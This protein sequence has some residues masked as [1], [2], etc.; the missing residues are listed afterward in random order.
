MPQSRDLLPV[1]L[2]DEFE[3]WLHDKGYETR[4]TKASYGEFEVRVDGKGYVIYRRQTTHAG[5]KTVHCSIH[6]PVVRLARKFLKERK[7]HE[8]DQG[9]GRQG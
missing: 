2:L 7:D 8:Q 1:T 3:T 9:T 5:Q 4:D 6:G